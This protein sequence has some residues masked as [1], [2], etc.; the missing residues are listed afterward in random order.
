MPRIDVASRLQQA[1]RCR[2]H[3]WEPLPPARLWIVP[4][5]AC[6]LPLIWDRG[7]PERLLLKA[8]G[9]PAALLSFFFL[10]LRL[11]H[12]PAHL[13][14]YQHNEELCLQPVGERPVAHAAVGSS[15][16]SQCSWPRPQE[17]LGAQK[18]EWVQIRLQVF[19][20]RRLLA[21]NTRVAGIEQNGRR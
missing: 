19:P 2:G 17:E 6:W 3:P 4:R 20:G 9:P 14:P 11:S 12:P 18:L 21:Q 10:G 15:R 1:G 7:R 13:T 5:G 16:R 8:T